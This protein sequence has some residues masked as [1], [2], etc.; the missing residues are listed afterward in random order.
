MALNMPDIRQKMAGRL[1]LLGSAAAIP[2]FEDYIC[3]QQADADNDSIGDACDNCPTAINADQAETDDDGTGD[4]AQCDLYHRWC[5]NA[6]C[7]SCR[8]HPIYTR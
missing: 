4:A 5:R 3:A 2:A 8:I 1:A 7:E 6:A